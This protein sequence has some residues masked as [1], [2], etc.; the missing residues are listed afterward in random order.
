MMN[1][2]KNSNLTFVQFLLKAQ[3]LAQEETRSEKGYAMMMTSIISIVMLSTLAAYMTMTNLSKSSTNA[4]VDGTNTFYAAESGLN[5]RAEQVR[6][7]FVLYSTPGNSSGSANPTNISNCFSSTIAVPTPSATNNDYE[8][9]NYSFRYNNNIA[10]AKDSNGDVI[11]SEQNGNNS[12]VDYIAYTFVSD[13]TNYANDAAGNPTTNPVP[14][15]IP[16]DETYGGLNVLEYKYTVSATAAKQNLANPD[17]PNFAGSAKT[18][19]QMNFKSRVIPLFQFAAFYDG[20]LELHSGT[21]MDISGR[22]HTNSNLYIQPIN[23][24]P[25][26]FSDKITSAGGI[27]RRVD[28][29]AGSAIGGA[30]RLKLSTGTYL[31]FPSAT[32]A[33]LVKTP[34]DLTVSGIPSQSANP[35]VNTTLSLS[36]S[37]I[38]KDRVKDRTTGIVPLKVPNAG[39]LRKRN[40]YKSAIASTTKEKQ[41][42]VGEYW[43]KADMRL[44][45]VPD[46]DAVGA[47]ETTPLTATEG[48]TAIT[49]GTKWNRNEAIIPFNFTSIQ[50]GTGSSNCSTTPPAAGSD[51]IATYVDPDRNGVSTLQC[52][53]FTKGQ[54]QSLRQPVMVLT[55]INQTNTALRAAEGTTLGAPAGLSTANPANPK[56]LRALQVALAS[57][58][59]PV[60]LDTLDKPFNDA[61]YTTSGSPGAVFKATF[62]DLLNKL[63]TLGTL[64]S[65]DV[66]TLTANTITP[67]QIAALGGAWFLPAPIQR[68]TSDIDTTTGRAN[69]NI[70]S[71]GFYD[72][73]ERRWITMLQTNIKSLTVWNRDGLYV[74]AD[75]ETM[76]TPYAAS[77][78]NKDLAFNNGTGDNFTTNKAFIIATADTTQPAGSLRRLGLGSTN[79]TEGGLVFHATVSDDLNGDGTTTDVTQVNINTTSTNTAINSAAITKADGKPAIPYELDILG[80]IKYEKNAD[81]ITNKL[82]SAG[83]TIPYTLDY[84]RKYWGGSTKQSP[85]GFAFNGGDFLP[86]AM[87]IATDQAIYI[88]GDFNN[89]SQPQTSVSTNIIAPNANRLPA[90]IMAD[91]I[92]TLSNQ[93]LT[94]SSIKSAVNHLGV[95]AG[96]IRCGLPRAVNGSIDLTEGGNKADSYI[97]TSPM[98]VNAAFLSFT[99]RSAGNCTNI[100]SNNTYKCGTEVA[101]PTKASGGLQNY[102]R[103]LED[104]GGAMYFNYSGSFVSLGTPNEYSGKWYNNTYFVGNGGST[105]TTIPEYYIIPARNFNFDPN[106]TSYSNLPPMTPKVT[107]LQ[108][109]VFKRTSQ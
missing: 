98:A 42:A 11:L 61:A 40:Y 30:V 52:N 51:P 101:N 63:N 20:D 83:N 53:V 65:G 45:L 16:A 27:F 104:W 75:S 35:L 15:V 17:N 25:T 2:Q 23:T 86:G 90:A 54:L 50:A 4:Y 74:D 56:I 69:S 33:Y 12:S 76:T 46:R 47:D 37:A 96:Q 10:S 97:V 88:Q 59:L 92:T 62:T 8:C 58:P 87:N 55:N 5:K 81:G 108:Q 100:T 49:S 31:N 67:N 107:Y 85:F 60:A 9:R 34:I 19:L 14:K 91:T 102:M 64:S 39:F 80:N 70:R 7:K 95:L 48:A 18:V 32:S 44:E 71:S 22:V 78:T 79:A 21:A 24:S 109:E 29:A 106:F 43:A 36:N 28:V 26:T 38:F 89:N 3:Y 105:N 1:K 41:L 94:N 72:S 93:C 73:R 103:M 99:D 57:T 13:S 68:L 6:Q 84:H 66:T 77:V 82:D